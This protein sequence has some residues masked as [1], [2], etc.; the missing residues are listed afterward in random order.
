MLEGKQLDRSVR[1]R[2][3][4]QW[5]KLMIADAIKALV[6]LHCS[7]MALKTPMWWW[8]CS[9]GGAGGTAVESV[10]QDL[11][12]CTKSVL[13]RSSYNLHNCH[14]L[15]SH[16]DPLMQE[17]RNYWFS[18]TLP[19]RSRYSLQSGITGNLTEVCRK[20][21]WAFWA[22]SIRVSLYSE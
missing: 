19:M 7:L 14:S 3:R 10:W 6:N 13:Q 20:K 17:E 1:W 18:S 16:G 15:M 2:G 12:T 4:R 8:R 21:I 5:I 22:S 9:S 11:L